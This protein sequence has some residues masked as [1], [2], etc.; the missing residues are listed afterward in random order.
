MARQGETGAAQRDRWPWVKG[1]TC[2]VANPWWS[3]RKRIQVKRLERS[4]NAVAFP[5]GYKFLSDDQ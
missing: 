4:G 1:K 5:E 3:Y 2:T